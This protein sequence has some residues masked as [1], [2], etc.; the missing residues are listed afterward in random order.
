MCYWYDLVGFLSLGTLKKIQTKFPRSGNCFFVFMT[1][2]LT[3]ISQEYSKLD[4]WGK[5]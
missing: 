3:K 4:S 5:L 1:F 2:W